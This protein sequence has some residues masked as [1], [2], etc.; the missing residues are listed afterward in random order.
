M[1]RNNHVNTL[2]LNV[3]VSFEKK[4]VVQKPQCLCT[5]LIYFILFRRKQSIQSNDVIQIESLQIVNSGLHGSAAR[6]VFTGL[7]PSRLIVVNSTFDCNPDDC[8]MN[9]MLLRTSPHELLWTFENNK[10]RAPPLDAGRKP[11]MC[12][13]PSEFLQSGLSC[14]LSWAVADCV[15]TETTATLPKV[16][17]SVLVVG[18]CEYLSVADSEGSPTALYL[19]RI[20]KCDV[21]RV[22]NTTKTIKI[23]HSN[24]VLH[25]GAMENNHFTSVSLGHTNLYKVAQRAV[26]N[27]TIENM[28]ISDST[29]SNWDA[30]A[31]TDARIE[32][33]SIVRSRIGVVTSLL[34]SV[35]HL[36]IQ[37]SVIFSGDGL[38]AMRSVQL[39]NNTVLCCCGREGGS[40][41]NDAR[42]RRRCVSHFGAFT[43]SSAPWGEAVLWP[44]IFILFMNVLTQC[45]VR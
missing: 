41:E 17:A 40:C 8:E 2:L 39:H 33:S 30:E 11:S 10:C 14:R 29:V 37:S 23:Y 1:L 7:T 44:S 15:C 12:V 22:P 3:I 38:S 32:H 26:H 34:R 25:Q 24:V 4:I 6:Y 16:N 20:N 31:A 13:Q 43:C 45:I 42:M 35:A 19:F 5:D 27:V 9:A 18:D 28:T 36:R 21:L